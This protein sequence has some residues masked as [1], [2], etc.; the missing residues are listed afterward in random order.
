MYINLTVNYVVFKY[1]LLRMIWLLKKF[2]LIKLLTTNRNAYPHNKYFK[3]KKYTY[4][5]IQSEPVGNFNVISSFNWNF[6]ENYFLDLENYKI[7]YVQ[8]QNDEQ[9]M[10]TMYKTYNWKKFSKIYARL[11]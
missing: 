10:Y 11:K 5:Q 2:F 8:F 4:K 6:L 1:L 9:R 3:I 7:R